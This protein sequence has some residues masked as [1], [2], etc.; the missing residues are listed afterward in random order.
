LS[1]ALSRTARIGLSVV[2]VAA[3]FGVLVAIKASVGIASW[4]A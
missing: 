1:G 3:V 2:G 4:K